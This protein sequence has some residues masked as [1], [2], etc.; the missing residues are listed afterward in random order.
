MSLK[1]PPEFV[2][3]RSGRRQQIRDS[4]ISSGTQSTHSLRI[5]TTPVGI[6]EKLSSAFGGLVGLQK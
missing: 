1:I 2:G 3:P 4:D 5:L 6:A